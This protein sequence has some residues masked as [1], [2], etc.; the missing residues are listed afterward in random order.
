MGFSIEFDLVYGHG[1]QLQDVPPASCYR[2]TAAAQ[3]QPETGYARAWA[4]PLVIRTDF[5]HSQN[6][7]STHTVLSRNSS[8]TKPA[9][10]RLRRSVGY[11]ISNTHGL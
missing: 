2:E 8:N 1:P 5:E 10:D 9:K 4:T 6:K 7:Q 3:G 11:A